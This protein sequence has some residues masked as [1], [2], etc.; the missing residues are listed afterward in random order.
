MVSQSVVKMNG[1][2]RGGWVI[3]DR[4]SDSQGLTTIRN[5]PVSGQKCGKSDRG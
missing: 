1:I 3:M 5:G 2:R 4:D